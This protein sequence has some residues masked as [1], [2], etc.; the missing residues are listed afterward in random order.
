MQAI[1][2]SETCHLLSHWFLAWLIPPP[3]RWRRDVPLKLVTCFHTSFF[4]GLFL[5]PE[6]GGVMFLRNLSPAVTLVS[7]LAYFS[8]LKMQATCS[9]E[10]CHLLSHWF[11]AWLIPP[12]WRWRRYVSPKLVTCCHA[13]F[14]LGLF[15]HPEDGGNMFLLITTAVR[16]FVRNFRHT[17]TSG[18]YEMFGKNNRTGLKETRFRVNFDL[19]ILNSTLLLLQ[20][21]DR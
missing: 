14:L 17:I 3:W 9:S 4:L 19:C 1:C 2:S 10:T 6:D 5:H 21:C 16:N 20:Y 18:G 8:T 12:P 11:L 13:G 7:C 15:L